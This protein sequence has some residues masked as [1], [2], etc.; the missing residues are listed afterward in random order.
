MLWKCQGP[1][2]VSRIKTCHL[3]LSCPIRSEAGSEGF[4]VFYL[5]E[6]DQRCHR[7][8][9]SEAGL[10]LC[11][12]SFFSSWCLGS[13]KF[14][15]NTILVVIILDQWVTGKKVEGNQNIQRVILHRLLRI[16]CFYPS[17]L[18]LRPRNAPFASGGPE[19]SWLQGG[20]V[21]HCTFQNV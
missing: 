13:C 6:E 11:S 2:L 17:D 10:S 1:P 21:W 16:T 7:T 3:V 12:P 8:K 15:R 9:L 20:E 18:A 4:Y 5:S 14:V 19:S